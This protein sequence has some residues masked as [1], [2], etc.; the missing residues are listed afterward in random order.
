MLSIIRLWYDNLPF[1]TLKF[2]NCFLTDGKNWNMMDSE[3]LSLLTISLSKDAMLSLI[4]P[5][6]K[7][8]FWI[9]VGIKEIF[10]LPLSHNDLK[11]HKRNYRH[12]VCG[13]ATA[14][15]IPNAFIVVY[16]KSWFT[17]SKAKTKT[18]N[19]DS[20]F[21]SLPLTTRIHGQITRIYRK[22]YWGLNYI[23]WT[24]RKGC[25]DFRVISFAYW[26]YIIVRLSQYFS[27]LKFQSPRTAPNVGKHIFWQY[28]P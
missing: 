12:S 1:I 17:R 19:A 6:N 13:F 5:I 27:S 8:L 16:R 21:S 15:P 4:R 7:S 18:M 11:S 3:F 2:K 26:G 24:Y 14:G 10:Q 20:K 22:N 28:W 9:I 23:I 25:I